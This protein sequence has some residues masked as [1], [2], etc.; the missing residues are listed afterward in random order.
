MSN[1]SL[2]VGAVVWLKSGGPAMTVVDVE[3]GAK[4]K[5]DVQ[6][7]TAS[8]D[9]PCSG[10]FPPAALTTEKPAAIPVAVR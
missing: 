2:E 3:V 9:H 7:L 4:R 10:P 5:I 8:A 6:W 1:E